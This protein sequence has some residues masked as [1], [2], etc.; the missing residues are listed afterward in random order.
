MGYPDMMRDILAQARRDSIASRRKAIE[1]QSIIDRFTGLYNR[2]YFNLRL[3]EEMA[4]ARLHGNRLSLILMNAGFSLRSDRGR[5]NQCGEKTMQI[6][7]E[8]IGDALAD[9]IGLAFLYDQDSIAV[10]L[11]E[12][13]ARDAS[14]TA[15]R[16]RDVILRERL[17]GVVLKAGTVQYNDHENIDELIQAAHDA[18][19]EY[20]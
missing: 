16:I 10:I 14:L 13:D 8:N 5:E 9:T 1:D 6:V 15:G 17:P 19:R 18:L 2:E 12:A 3:D 7:A 4:R 11:P 20:I